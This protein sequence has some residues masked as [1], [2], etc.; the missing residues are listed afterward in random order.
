[1]L[2][3]SKTYR[4]QFGTNNFNQFGVSNYDQFFGEAVEFILVITGY[5][6]LEPVT[7]FRLLEQIDFYRVLENK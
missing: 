5:Y 6:V 4:H 7:Y 2:L 1:M 3:K